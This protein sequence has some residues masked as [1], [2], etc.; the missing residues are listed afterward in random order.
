M[1]RHPLTEMNVKRITQG[2]GDSP[3]TEEGKK[4]AHAL[5]KKLSEFKI[6]KIYTS[7]LGRCVQTAEIINEY[8]N[9]EIVKEK[10]FREQNF[11]EYNEKPFAEIEKFFNKHDPND[12][13]PGGESLNDATYRALAKI[14]ELPENALVVT[15]T[16][17]VVGLRAL[18][19]LQQ[20]IL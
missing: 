3:L 7:D 9:V 20:Q 14:K 11:G 19:R 8:L 16:A 15:H 4:T 5:G 17:I 6:S 18:A 1:V 10:A 13:T 2:W 12:K